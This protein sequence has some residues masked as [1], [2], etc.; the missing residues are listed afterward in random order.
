MGR[1]HLFHN[2]LSEVHI[3]EQM[4]LFIIIITFPMKRLFVEIKERKRKNSLNAENDVELSDSQSSKQN[5]VSICHKWLENNSLVGTRGHTALLITRLACLPPSWHTGLHD[6]W[7]PFISSQLQRR[8][9]PL[10]SPASSLP[11]CR[12]ANV[13]SYSFVHIV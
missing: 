2:P 10:A 6:G 12:Q 5:P 1:K 7:L 9:S 13:A 3:L 11:W 4:F 8:S